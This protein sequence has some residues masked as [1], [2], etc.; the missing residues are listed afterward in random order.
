MGAP[1]R[2]RGRGWS[3][4]TAKASVMD[5][6]YYECWAIPFSMLKFWATY[7]RPVSGWAGPA[8]VCFIPS[9][10]LHIYWKNLQRFAFT[11]VLSLFFF[12]APIAFRFNLVS[13]AAIPS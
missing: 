13:T 9:R 4:K 11:G 12:A 8:V 7:V 10:V 3:K 1:L 6:G 5:G 2:V